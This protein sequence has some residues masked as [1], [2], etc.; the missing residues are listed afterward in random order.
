MILY[1]A[2]KG[3]RDSCDEIA[4]GRSLDPWQDGMVIIAVFPGQGSQTPG[5]LEPWLHLEGSR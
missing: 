5:F 2:H 1:A 4:R 3:R